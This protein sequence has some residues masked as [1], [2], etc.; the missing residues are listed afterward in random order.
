VPLRRSSDEF[1]LTRYEAAGHMLISAD[2]EAHMC[3]SLNQLMRIAL[4]LTAI[5]AALILFPVTAHAGSGFRRAMDA[6]AAGA[7]RAAVVINIDK[8][9]QRMTVF[10]DGVERYEWPVSTGRA[11]YS[12]PSGAYTA[13]SMNKI[14]YSKQWDNAPMP[15]SIFFMRDGHAI[16]GS[17]DVKNL[18]RPASH[19]CVRISPKNAAILY[20][21]VQENGLENTKVVVTGVSPGGE[22]EVARGQ[23]SP[24][25]GFPGRSI[26]V[27][28]YNGSQGYYGSPWTYSPW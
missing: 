15:H 21:L 9:T 16:H 8:T 22:Y 2:V 28:Y 4:L 27:P 24:R 18:G 3:T 1:Q 13:T 19:G 12:T 10:L 7:K 5:D 26:G 14:W 6:G 23:T 17:F 20:A 25:G 11:G